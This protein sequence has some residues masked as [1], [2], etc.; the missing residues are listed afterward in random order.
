MS[1]LETPQSSYDFEIFAD[2]YQIQLRD[3]A[4]EGDLSKSWDKEALNNLFAIALGIIGMSTA[5]N[6]DVPVKV[7]LTK[8][9]PPSDDIADWDQVVEA[10]ITIS[11][12]T[13]I[14]A[15][16]TDYLPD[17]VRIPVEP[18]TYRVRLYYAHLESISED[19]LEGEDQYQIILWSEGYKASSILKRK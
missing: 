11:S 5:R 18:G 3:E 13:I 10:S 16:P 4:A 17:A 8:S 15:G 1:S 2:Y 14:I 7:T 12:G 19:G 9:A 6:T